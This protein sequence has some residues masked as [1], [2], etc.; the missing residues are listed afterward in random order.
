MDT[1]SFHSLGTKHG[2]E[3]VVH[4]PGPPGTLANVHN[5]IQSSGEDTETILKGTRPENPPALLLRVHD[6]GR[7]VNT[8][9]PEE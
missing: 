1:K 5:I 2:H 8:G 3:R 7:V 6:M 9:G 4:K